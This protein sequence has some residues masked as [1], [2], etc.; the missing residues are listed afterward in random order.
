MLRHVEGEEHLVARVLEAGNSAPGT[1]EQGQ[2]MGHGRGSR[3]HVC[4]VEAQARARSLRENLSCKLRRAMEMM[5]GNQ[6]SSSEGNQRWRMRG[7][8]KR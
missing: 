1:Q 6:V 7:R 4:E 8:V 5:P 2:R 3:Q